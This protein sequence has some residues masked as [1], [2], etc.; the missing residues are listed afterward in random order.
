MTVS[1]PD[2]GERLSSED[3]RDAWPLLVPEDRLSGFRALDPSEADDFFLSRRTRDQRDLLLLLPAG[4]RRLW[5]RSLPPDDAADL[6][7]AVPAA[8]ERDVLLAQLDAATQKDVR[9]L[10]AYA[11][12]DAG[13]LMNPRYARVRP[14]MS[15]DEAITYLRRQIHEQS[16]SLNYV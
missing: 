5:L 10:L 6:L 16:R 1:P 11:E 9:A 2:P 13:G 7:Q 14:D 3:L 4:E 12:D 15:A 8:E